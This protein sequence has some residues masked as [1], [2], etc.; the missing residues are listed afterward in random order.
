MLYFEF[1]QDRL[2]EAHA[3]K[4]FELSVSAIKGA[5]VLIF[6]DPARAS[7]VRLQNHS[8]LGGTSCPS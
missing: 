7:W 6:D 3:L 2:A 4:P 8:F 5:F 1:G